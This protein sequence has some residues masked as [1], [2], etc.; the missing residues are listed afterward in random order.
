M[1]S[2]LHFLN[3][4]LY[5]LLPGTCLLCDAKTFRMLDLCVDCETVLPWPENVCSIC[6][7]PLPIGEIICGK[8]V[9]IRPA[10]SR[11]HAAFIYQYPID[12][13]ILNFK[14]HHDLLTGC[15]LT[16]LLANSLPSDHVLPDLLIPMPLH[17][18]AQKA[19]GFNQSAEISRVLSRKWNI[20]VNHNRC[21][22]TVDTAEQ[23]SLTAID[24]AKN[25]KG[26]F[27]ITERFNGEH[28]GIVDDVVTTG[29]SV[30]ELTK[31]FMANGAGSVN[32]YCLAR[33]PL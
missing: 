21:S 19:R 28:V 8:C 26:V 24:R 23:K 15:L 29:A 4:I 13:L 1:H 9:V 33:T 27:S 25:V 11:C 16:N 2:M 12:K 14:N 10:Y 32:V 6:S 18:R 30:T 22:R 31:L 3:N 7:Y 20:A 5:T 17:N